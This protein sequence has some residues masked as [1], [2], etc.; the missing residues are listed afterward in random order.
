[1]MDINFKVAQLSD[2]DVLETFMREYYEFD[3]LPFD[4][5]IARQALI[6]FLDDETL[7]RIWLIQA[8]GE[9]VGYL[10]LTLG[11]SLEYHGRDAFIDEIYVRESR[12]GQGIGTK[13][14]EFAE[15]AGRALGVNALHLEVERENTKA[16]AFYRMVGFEDH[17]RYLLTKWISKQHHNIS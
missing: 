10:A 13:A 9:A 1:M 11:Y 15:E 16:Q 5:S 12:R 4:E 17:D 3:H 6:N 2:I 8:D 14:I 7:G